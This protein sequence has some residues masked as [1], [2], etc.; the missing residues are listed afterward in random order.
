[1]ADKE[2]N[3]CEADD[4][5]EN[6]FRK[7]RLWTSFKATLYTAMSTAA[8]T[9]VLIKM[10]NLAVDAVQKS[11]V[12]AVETLNNPLTYA[13]IGGL[14]AVG[15]AVTYLAQ[16]E[17][18]EMQCL[19]DDHLARKNAAALEHQRTPVHEAIHSTVMEHLDKAQ[20]KERDGGKWEKYLAARDLRDAPAA[21]QLRQ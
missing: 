6:D 18:T 9:G 10:A 15:T 7:K 3:A 13:V 11:G 19:N 12:E 8:F 5:A 1:M 21:S 16:I 4:P 2:I 14:A 20:N 17:W